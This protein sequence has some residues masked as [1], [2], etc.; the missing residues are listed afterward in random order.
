M[1]LY[2][3]PLLLTGMWSVSNVNAQAVQDSPDVYLCVDDKGHREYKNTGN[4]KGCKK[5]E[6]I[7]LTV[8]PAVKPRPI[9]ASNNP[10]PKAPASAP[11]D[12]PRVDSSTQK[13]RDHDRKQIW[14]DE[15][16]VEEEKLDSLK[17]Q[18]NDGEPER[19]GDETNFSKYQERVARLR[20]DIAR[21]EKNVEALK[22]ELA[23]V[24]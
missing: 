11:A 2:W 12:F 1:K 18:Y 14:L 7:G 20:E 17:K 3:V 5:I 22:R 23:G 15:L 21:T 10:A 4:V 16:K 6:L 24:K 8:V 13:A 9:L 19:R